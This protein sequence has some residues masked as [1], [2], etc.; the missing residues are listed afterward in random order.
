MQP[1]PPNDDPLR[2]DVEE[3]DVTSM[4]RPVYREHDEPVDGYEPVPVWIYIIFAGLL[5]WGGWYAATYSGGYR[6]DVYDQPQPRALAQE[7]IPD[8][9]EELAEL[10]RRLYV[11]CALCHQADGGGLAKNHPPLKDSEWVV[12][13]KASK[14]RLIR[15]ALYGVKGDFTVKGEKFTG[16]MPGF[17]GL[18]KDH[19][20]AAVLTYIRSS[21]GHNASPV[22]P[23]EVTE[24]RQLERERLTNGMGAF[25]AEDLLKIK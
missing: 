8:T 21:W 23:N 10:G 5:F 1:T 18:W 3:A 7:P 25:S 2:T 16:L 9:P 17:G 24:I 12:G 22:L 20:V 4:M 11:N 13:D 15:I 19:Q 6:S 14:E